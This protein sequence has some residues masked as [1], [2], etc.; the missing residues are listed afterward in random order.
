MIG[1]VLL[2]EDNATQQTLMKVLAKRFGLD[3]RTVWSAPQ[4]LEALNQE[5]FDLILMDWQLPGMDG[6][7]C[8]SLIREIDRARGRRTPVVAVTAADAEGNR[9]HCLQAGMDDF[10]S[11]PF[12]IEEFEQL[13]KRWLLAPNTVH[14]AF[15][16]GGDFNANNERGTEAPRS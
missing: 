16:A 13:I 10:L 8:T 1:K 12:T 7:Q 3:M 9:E 11:K 6:L 4:A 15:D 2:V 14:H 5:N